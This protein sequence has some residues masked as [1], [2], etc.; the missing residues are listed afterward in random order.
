MQTVL[1][2]RR[3]QLP[4][5]LRAFC[6]IHQLDY[7]TIL[8]TNPKTE[9][10]EVQTYIL[11]L[12]PSDTSGFNTCPNAGNCRAVCLNFAG[13]PAYMQTKQNAR[14]RRTLAFYDSQ[15][16]FVQLLFVAICDKIVRHNGELVAI[17]LNGTSDICWENVEL[18]ID[19]QFADFIYRKFGLPFYIGN[20][21]HTLFSL[22]Q[23]LES[24][25]GRKL[26]QFY[27]YTKLSRNW[28]KC[29]QLD[30][31]LTFSFDGWNNQTNLTI[32]KRALSAGVNI[33]A[34]FMVKRGK[35]LPKLAEV[36]S[37]VGGDN[38]TFLPVYDGDKS[39]F[40]PADPSGGHIIGLRFKLP[41]GI[42]YN[43]SDKTAFC[44]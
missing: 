7:K 42:K 8:S 43:H 10:S 31:H 6:Q 33:A 3:A 22:V 21:N 1:I 23:H 44:M 20:G 30:Y 18:A 35:Q 24:M 34:A 29:K 17:R 38:L 5:N 4:N 32:A 16:Q 39:D 11:H 12:A 27:D 25:I 15:Q 37:I 19:Q 40:R 28:A 26:V 13:N 41:H 2:N 36:T 9:K 14:I